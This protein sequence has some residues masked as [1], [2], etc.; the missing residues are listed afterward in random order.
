MGVRHRRSRWSW[1]AGSHP[2]LGWQLPQP[3]VK[4]AQLPW[5]QARQPATPEAAVH[6]S[7]GQG[8]VHEARRQLPQRQPTMPVSCWTDSPGRHVPPR[9]AC[10]LPSQRARAVH[11][12]HQMAGE[13]PLFAPAFTSLAR[14]TRPPR[15]TLTSLLT[16]T[17]ALA[18]KGVVV[19]AVPQVLLLRHRPAVQRLAL[20]LA[21][22]PVS[23]R[24]RRCAVAAP[25]PAAVVAPPV[26]APPVVAPAGAAP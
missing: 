4:A 3:F 10:S 16:R 14:T 20:C 11:P 12:P 22:D 5:R 6:P 17:T 9:L 15:H 25:G 7:P 23:D 24:A 1:R 18:A 13:H 21:L 19:T 8:P 2:A 26:V